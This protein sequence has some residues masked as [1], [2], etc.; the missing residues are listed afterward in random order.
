MKKKGLIVVSNYYEDI[1]KN[2]INGCKEILK[3]HSH[4]FDVKIV[5]GSLEIPTL[6]SINI[7]KKKY[8]FFIALGCIIK[9]KTPHFDFISEAITKSLLDLSIANNIPVTNGIITSLNYTQAKERSS[10]NRNK[11]KEAALAAISLLKNI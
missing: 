10:K 11:G 1:S 5:N 3:K 8:N 2:L 6:I 9:G 4:Q 7:K